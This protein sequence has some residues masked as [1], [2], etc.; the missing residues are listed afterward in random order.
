MP[1]GAVG[2]LG[3]GMRQ[4]VG[5]GDCPRERGNFAGGCGAFQWRLCLCVQVREAIE[6]PF[7]VLSGVG[8]G[9][10]VLDGVHIP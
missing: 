10:G 9:I 7:G 2:P 4:V 8:P 1:F 3:P 5:V 6:L